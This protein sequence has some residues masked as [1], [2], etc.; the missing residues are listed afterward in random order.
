V[1]I[2]GSNLFVYL[3]IPPLKTVSKG[4]KMK[5]LLVYPKYPRTFWSFKYALR[6]TLVKKATHPPLALLTVASM[7]PEDWEKKLIDMNVSSLKDKDIRWADLVFISAIS[8][9]RESVRKVIDRCKKIGVKIVA[10]GPLFTSSFNKFD[11]VDY[12]VLNEAELTLSPFLKDLESG[13]AKHIYT[14]KKW[15][16]IKKTPIPMW[17]LVDMKKYVSMNIQYSRGCPFNCEFCDIPILYGY[18]PRTKDAKQVIEELESLY[19]HGWREAVFFVDDN[20]IGNKERLKREILP[21]ITLWMEERRRPFTFITQASLDLS[22]DEALMRLMVQAGFDTVFVGIETPSEEGLSECNKFPNKNRNL[23]RSIKKIQRFGLQVQG[24]FIV[25]FDSDQPSIFERQIDF[26]QK[27]GIATAMVS[28]LYAFRG[29]RLYKRMEGENR[30]VDN[31]SN[32]GHSSDEYTDCST[33]IIPKMQYNTLIDG[34]KR[35]VKTIYSPDHYYERV[36]RFLK[37]YKLFQRIGRFRFSY[38][39]AFF[40]SILI[41]GF[42]SKERIRYWKLFFETLF[43]RPRL[44]PLAISFT[45]CGFHFRKV[46]ERL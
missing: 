17:K 7:L 9:Q 46:F 6:F 11:D 45:L 33:N 31:R 2:R 21:A 3:L 20:F 16:D 44:F 26:I 19:Q 12:L 23:I 39:F 5:V 22:D 30:L 35:I 8:I 1:W 14:T 13:R 32:S 38:L 40:N 28:L 24:G 42:L 36:R 15:A 41:L 34:Y 27:S 25:G 10:G 18:R 43:N 4:C 29:T 37:D